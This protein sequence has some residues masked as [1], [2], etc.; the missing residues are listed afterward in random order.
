MRADIYKPEGSSDYQVRFAGVVRHTGKQLGNAEFF[1]DLINACLADA[2]VPNDRPAGAQQSTID[3]QPI[4]TI[5]A[6][7]KGGPEA[8]LDWTK[9]AGA[10]GAVPE[11]L[12]SAFECYIDMITWQRDNPELVKTPD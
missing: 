9:I 8:I 2:G 6:Q 3:S 11:K 1:C 7:D 12:R 10:H 4:F 5:R